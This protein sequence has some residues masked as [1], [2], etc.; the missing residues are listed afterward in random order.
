MR[1]GFLPRKA[2]G[3][4]EIGVVECQ[5]REPA[6]RE[7]LRIFARCPFLDARQT[8]RHDNGR[9]AGLPFQWKQQVPTQ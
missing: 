8:R 3:F 2:L 5:Y 9:E 4:T 6:P 7:V 1:I